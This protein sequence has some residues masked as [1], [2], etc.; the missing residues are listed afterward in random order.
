MQKIMKFIEKHGLIIILML[1]IL[2]TCTENMSKRMNEKK[3]YRQLDSIKT[4]IKLTRQELQK[5]I[6]FE[7]LKTELRMIE[8]TDR[9]MM[10]KERQT[11]I[12]KELEN[13]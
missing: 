1:M 10:D 8:S 7:G 6:K 11:E 2:A 5:E 13:K 4:E 9:R 3:L 12:R